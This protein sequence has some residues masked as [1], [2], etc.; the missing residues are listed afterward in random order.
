MIK[1]GFRN[2][3]L[4]LLMLLLFAS[5]RICVEKI[6]KSHPYKLNVD[7]VIFFLIFFSQSFIA[8]IIQLYYYCKKIKS[9]KISHKIIST[10]TKTNNISKDSKF[11][12]FILIFFGSIF[13]FV[14]INIRGDDVIKFEKTEENNSQLEVRIKGIQIIISSLLC[15][16]TIRLN[17]YR[18]QKLSLIVISF[19]LVFIIILELLKST[20]IKNKILSILSC[21][22]SCLSRAFMDVT[23]KY[24]F[25]FDYLNII[26][27]LIYEGLFGLLFF[28]IY[29]IS[30]KTYQNQGRNILKDMSKFDWSFASFLLLALL[31]II[32]SGFRNVYRVKTNNY[33]SPMSRALFESTLDPFVFIYNFLTQ[34][35]DNQIKGK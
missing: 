29:F 18:H 10:N 35:T 30:S 21:V 2:N 24:L 22:I 1:F 28:I 6:I 17:V 12:K 5:L 15:Y 9:N 23:E 33:Y 13:Y 32:I 20:S 31:Y 14:G 16:F 19:F 4:Y 25:E 3:N 26:S 27:M 34:N 8:S 7:F 11:K